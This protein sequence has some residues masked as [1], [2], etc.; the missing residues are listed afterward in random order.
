MDI[1]QPRSTPPPLFANGGCCDPGA[2]DDPGIRGRS[3]LRH[4]YGTALAQGALSL[5]V[6]NGQR[7]TNPL[8]V[9]SL[10]LVERWVRSVGGEARLSVVSLRRLWSIRTCSGGAMSWHA[11]LPSVPQCARVTTD[12]RSAPGRSRC[13]R[14]R[15]S[16]G[17][18]PA[19]FPTS[20]GSDRRASLSN[21]PATLLCRGILMHRK[22]IGDTCGR[23]RA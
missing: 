13:C 22:R 10:R 2:A 9:T 8:P 14:A 4:D 16:T 20:F 12:C 3:G 5:H 1:H 18:D 23:T 17:C 15:P 19:P 21:T 7:I 11:G 6:A